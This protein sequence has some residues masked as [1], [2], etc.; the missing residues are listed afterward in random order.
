MISWSYEEYIKI[1]ELR[2]KQL[3][4]KRQLGDGMNIVFISRTCSDVEYNRIKGLYELK[5]FSPSQIMYSSLLKGLACNLGAAV[6]CISARLVDPR[7]AKKKRAMLR[8]IE[9]DNEIKY[10]Y[11]NMWFLPRLSSIWAKITVFIESVRYFSKLDKRNTVVICDVLQMFSANARMAAHMFGIPVV[12]YATDLPNLLPEKKHLGLSTVTRILSN[13]R[14]QQL[15]KSMTKYD[16]YVILASEMNRYI[17]PAKKPFLIAE[18]IVDPSV[19]MPDIFPATDENKP[20]VVLYAGST[21]FCFGIGVLLESFA[22]LKTPNVELHIYGSGDYTDEIIQRAK[23]DSRIKYFGVI[24]HSEVVDAERNAAIL[25][26]PRPTDQSFTMV[27]F[28]SKTSEY[29]ASGRPVLTTRLAGIPEEYDQYLWYI[30]NESPE[31]IAKSIDNIF[32]LPEEMRNNKSATAKQFIIDNKTSCVQ[33][34]R[35]YEF[36]GTVLG[37]KD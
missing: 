20:K 3:I 28:P 11:P 22:Y 16:G 37:V 15:T 30:E 35:I 17:N 25:V 26:N 12:G 18:C 13:M 33:G 6:C 32:S 4:N 24:S 10:I 23:N 2:S 5:E 8:K 7:F 27:S 29:M 19:I 36:L 9:L 21:N 1:Q 31:G 14:K 34:R